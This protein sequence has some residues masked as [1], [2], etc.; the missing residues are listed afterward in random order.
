M[1]IWDSYDQREQFPRDTLKYHNKEG[2]KSYEN[3]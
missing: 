1:E 2:A 3:V